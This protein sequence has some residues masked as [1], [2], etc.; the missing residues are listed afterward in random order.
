MRVFLWITLALPVWAETGGVYRLDDTIKQPKLLR[1]VEP[2]YSRAALD[3]RIQGTVMFEIVVSEKGLPTDINILSPLGFGL[4]ERAQAALEQWRFAPATKD[5]K[6]VNVYAMVEVSFRLMEAWF[7][8]KLERQRTVFN[9][10]IAALKKRDSARTPK[11]IEDLERLAEQ[12]F[13]PAMSLVGSLAREGEL[14]PKNPQRGLTLLQAA[15]AK[16]HGPALSEIGQMY[17]TGDQ[18]PR[19]PE[20]GLQ[21]LRDA[22]VL[23]SL[24]AQYLLGVLYLKGQDVPPEPDRARRYFRLCASAGDSRCQF[25]L[26]KLLTG[27]PNRTEREYLQG[28]AWYRLAGQKGHKEAQQA[29]E[30]EAPQLT[31]DQRKWVERLQSQLAH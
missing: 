11:A 12:K 6:P 27:P 13:P 25:Q 17:Y 5:G 29:W 1:K 9:L 20:K 2:Q 19:D 10:A 23:G 14:V 3:A 21:L 22:A 4:D 7:D 24:Q 18:L 8:Q 16:H 30:Q 15:A 31:A 28:V 26:A